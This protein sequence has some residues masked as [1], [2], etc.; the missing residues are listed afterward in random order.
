MLSPK[1]GLSLGVSQDA[2]A[3]TLRGRDWEV[4]MPTPL[5]T[6]MKTKDGYPAVLSRRQ[7]RAQVK[8]LRDFNCTSLSMPISHSDLCLEQTFHP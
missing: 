3:S 5:L 7:T 1:Q 6:I 2:R 8:L 4:Q